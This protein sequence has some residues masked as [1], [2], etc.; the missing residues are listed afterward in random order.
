MTTPQGPFLYDDD[1]APLHTGTP[2]RRQGLLIALLLGTV[3]VAVAM[4]AA[5]VLVKGTPDEQGREVV[6]VF[7][8]ALEE[9]DIETAHGLLCEAERARI[10]PEGVA[11]EYLA[12]GDGR[13]VGADEG[14][15]DGRDVQHVRVRW[16]DGTESAF[17]VLSE[18][19]PR[20]CGTAG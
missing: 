17:V 15:R 18:D 13:I 16:T 2:R 6:S 12:T 9:Q 8:A 14:E 19:G 1:P 11:G 20:I 7:L 4:V 10:A 5:L 3:V